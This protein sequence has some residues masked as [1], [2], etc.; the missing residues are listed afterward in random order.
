MMVNHL[1]QIEY[2]TSY[3]NPLQRQIMLVVGGRA[4]TYPDPVTQKYILW[5]IGRKGIP[6]ATTKAALQSLV[7]RGYIRR[8]IKFKGG[9]AYV[10][11]RFI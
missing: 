7:R 8:A 4:R 1:V 5:L 11:I 6:E 9:A 2:Y 3:I 10:Q